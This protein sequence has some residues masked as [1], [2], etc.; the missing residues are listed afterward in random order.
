MYKQEVKIEYRD[1]VSI[2]KLPPYKVK[3]K[4]RYECRVIVNYLYID[5]HNLRAYLAYLFC[6]EALC[7]L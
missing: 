5:V 1:E 3:Q 4:S 6:R 2:Y 7:G